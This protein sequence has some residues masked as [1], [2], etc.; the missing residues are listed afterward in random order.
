MSWHFLQE[1]EAVSWGGSCLDGAPSALSS[2]IPTLEASSLHGN[3]TDTFPDSPSGMMS[4]RSTE[5]HGAEP[6]TLFQGASPARTYQ[7]LDEERVSTENDLR[8][9][10]EHC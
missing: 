2:L 8:S 3:A 9:H 10:G 4:E 7:P 5:S 1:Q 6:L